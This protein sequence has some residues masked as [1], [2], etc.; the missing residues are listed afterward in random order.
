MNEIDKDKFKFP[1]HP[2]FIANESENNEDE[3]GDSSGEQGQQSFKMKIFNSGDWIIDIHTLKLKNIR[4]NITIDLN[5]L[6]SHS[7]YLR[8]FCTIGV[9]AEWDIQGLITVL[10]QA[11]QVIFDDTIDHVLVESVSN[12]GKK[13]DWKTGKLAGQPVKPHKNYF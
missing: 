13:I 12:Q 4:H 11:S 8:L 3:D 9:N 2:N 1:V 10:N 6:N 7:R 5:K